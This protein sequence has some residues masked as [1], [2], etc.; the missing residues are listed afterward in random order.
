M[1]LTIEQLKDYFSGRRKS[2][3]IP[4]A[5][6]GTDFQ[7][8]VWKQLTQ[9][10]WGESNT[11]GEVARFCNNPKASRAVGMANNRNPLPIIIPCHR[12]V[13]S[14]GALVGYGGG[15]SIKR[16]LLQHEGFTITETD[17]I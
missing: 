11:Y 4:L 10:P 17:K 7:Q 12:V 5:P 3:D 14:N 13:G 15:L 2:F 1:D 9:I 16:W 8:K 6:E